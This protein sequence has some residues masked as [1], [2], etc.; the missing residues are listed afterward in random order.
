VHNE[1]ADALLSRDTLFSGKLVCL[2]HQDGYRYSI[3]AVLLAHFIAPKP[4]EKILDLGAGCG[5]VSLIVAYR[6]PSVHV[7]SLEIQKKLISLLYKNRRLNNFDRRIDIVEGDLVEINTLV[8]AGSFDRIVCNPPYG[9]LGSGRMNS[10]SEQAVARHEIRA[11][12]AD[13]SDA[14]LYSLKNRGKAAFIYPSGKAAVLL[15]R[16]KEKRLEPKRFQI[17][18]SYPGSSARL[19]LVEA[20][21]GGGEELEILPPFYV[22]DRPGGEYSREMARLYLSQ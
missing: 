15:A 20:V 9:K 19:V 1:S 17:V 4:E 14:V 10:G 16:L 21:K 6:H 2:Q 11:T 7:S 5:I 22:Y 3:D 12:L 8:Q 18:Y 13:V